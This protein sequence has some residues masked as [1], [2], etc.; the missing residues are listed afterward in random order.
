VSQTVWFAT[1]AAVVVIAL[2]VAAFATFSAMSRVAVP[3]VTGTALGVAT[4]RLAQVGLKSVSEPG[5]R[6][7]PN[8]VIEQVR[9]DNRPSETYLSVV[10]EREE[11]TMPD[12]VGDGRRRQHHR[13]LERS[14]GDLDTASTPSCRQRRG[15][16]RQT[17]DTVRMRS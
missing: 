6:R 8:Q 7:S 5:F 11:F 9:R 3:D 17:G 12:V 1:A 10:S 15:A 2:I 14:S 13:G 4:A 16:R